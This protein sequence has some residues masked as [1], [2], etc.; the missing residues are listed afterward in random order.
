[1]ALHAH[2]TVMQP[3]D[4]PLFPTVLVYFIWYR[5]KESIWY[6]VCYFILVKQILIA[7]VNLAAV[8]IA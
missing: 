3:E 4:Q 5:K 6:T 2:H 7:E 1:M 8:F